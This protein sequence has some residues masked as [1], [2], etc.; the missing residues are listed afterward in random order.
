MKFS[1]RFCLVCLS[2]FCQNESIIGQSV[3]VE[4]NVG[5]TV[6]F[7]HVNDFSEEIFFDTLIMKEKSTF[8]QI[9]P[10]FYGRF[11][12][13]WTWGWHTGL[14]WRKTERSSQNMELSKSNDIFG[15]VGLFIRKIFVFPDEPLEVFI[16][17]DNTGFL[18]FSEGEIADYG[19]M[20]LL[21]LGVSYRLQERF[22]IEA[23][24]NGALWGINDYRF[25][26]VNFWLGSRFRLGTFK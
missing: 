7:S 5:L 15:N 14:M 22:A 6:T 1:L 4:K 16:E 13:N 2:L 21:G 10:Y 9:N 26:T 18:K 3:F 20:S 24:V 25:G 11:A 12:K 23:K 19:E 8:L 17:W